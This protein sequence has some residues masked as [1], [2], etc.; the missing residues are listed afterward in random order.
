MIFN[1]WFEKNK[2]ELSLLLRNDELEALY[3]AW[4]A[5]Y[6]AAG[7]DAMGKFAVSYEN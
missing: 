2:D 7:L 5:G 1:E 4:L 6:E 3:R